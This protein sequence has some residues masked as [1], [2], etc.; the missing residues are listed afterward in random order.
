MENE[1]NPSR[2]GEAAT[3][4]VTLTT[5]LRQMGDRGFTGQFAAR[6]GMVMCFT[7]RTASAPSAVDVHGLRRL[8]GASD[9]ADMLAVFAVRCPHCEARGTLVAN[10]GPEATEDDARV[11]RDL[12]AP[13]DPSSDQRDETTSAT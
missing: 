13:P 5:V 12:P 3:D 11:I 6:E 10:F 2:D 8:E 1:T 7:C 9:P 4:A